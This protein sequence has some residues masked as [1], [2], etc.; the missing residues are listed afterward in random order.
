MEFPFRKFQLGKQTPRFISIQ[1]NNRDW[2]TR[3]VA[4]LACNQQRCEMIA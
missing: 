3:R 2:F 4:K 1:I